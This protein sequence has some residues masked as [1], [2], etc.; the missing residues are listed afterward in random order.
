MNKIA[1]A[2]TSLPNAAPL[3]YIDAAAKAGFDGIG[4]RLFASP[5]VNYPSFHAVAGDAALIRQVKDAL[6]SSGLVL[7]D[8]LSF[9]L[10]PEMDIASMQPALELGA[11]L[12]STYALVIGDDPDWQ[13]Q[14]DNFAR[15]CEAAKQVGLIASIEAPVVQ[16]K[17][18][19]LPKAVQLIADSGT[20]NAVICMDPF[21]FYRAGHTL[22]VLYAQDKR[23]FPYCQFD[24]G[25]DELPAPGGRTEPGKGNVPLK[26]ILDWLPADCPLTIE[27]SAPRGSNLSAIEWAITC[28]NNMR[29]YLDAHYAANV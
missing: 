12:G 26:E 18:N 4:L 1:L 21:H 3:E 27:W 9:Y 22:D 5:G 13:R 20:D 15:F 2:P 6:N 16:R 11:E 17:V 24:D 29:G 28:A 8:V 14:V 10:Q 19:T 23:L 25:T 7:Y